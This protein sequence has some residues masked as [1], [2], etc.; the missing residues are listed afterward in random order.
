MKK[1]EEEWKVIEEAP[2][3]EISN[4]GR[5]RNTRSS[6]L[7]RPHVKKYGENKLE[8]CHFLCVEYEN[9]TANRIKRTVGKLVA[10]AFVPNPNG[11]KQVIYI[12]GDIS[13][14][15]FTNLEWVKSIFHHY[16]NAYPGP[17]RKQYPA[18]LQLSDLR[19]NIRLLTG[20]EKALTEGT[21]AEF[22]YAEIMPI[23]RDKINKKSK[24]WSD[25]LREECL[26]YSLDE[27]ITDINNGKHVVS[28]SGY[29][30]N[31]YKKFRNIN[32]N[33]HFEYNERDINDNDDTPDDY[34]L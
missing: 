30:L 26:S 24:G 8:V 2:K 20:F 13:N 9:R 28:F 23:Y 11:Y 12:D 10:Q 14:A 5:C 22:V 6:N 32:N 21:A 15:C 16:K 29:F 18:D 3:Y 17:K 34:P 25:D 7:M 19:L 31:Y 4:M 1:I 33:K 27:L